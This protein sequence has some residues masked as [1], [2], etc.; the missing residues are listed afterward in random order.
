MTT[1]PE[2]VSR[3]ELVGRLG[4]K[5]ELQHTESGTPYVRLSIATSEQYKDRGGQD[6]ERT[7]WH[8]AVAWG[9][10]AK[11]IAEDFKKG[12]AVVLSGVLRVNSYEKDGLKNRVE[13]ISIDEMRKSTDKEQ[14]KNEIRLVGVVREEPKI[15][16]VA[17][18]S[19][20]TTLSVATKTMVPGSRGDREREDWH[21][22]TFWGKAAEAARSLKAGDTVSVEGSLRHRDV[23]GDEGRIRRLSTVEG[24]RFE[25]LDHA[26]DRAKEPAKARTVAPPVRQRTKGL[27]R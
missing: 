21:S 25:I 1:T 7:S 24:Q 3:A 18:G 15:R 8:R 11:T 22:V 16:D 2:H 13:E 27:E 6:Q 19:A 17:G 26:K 20:M 5:P 4:Q 23:P 9:D 12:D 10:V 14:S